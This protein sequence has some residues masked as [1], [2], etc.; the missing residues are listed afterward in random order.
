M[1]AHF[2][3]IPFIRVS[4]KANPYLRE[5]ELDFIFDKKGIKKMCRD[6]LNY[7]TGHDLTF[8]HNTHLLML[9]MCHMLGI[10]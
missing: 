3:H 7:Y 9:P 4:K 8:S 1:Q 2:R 6:V 10:S 5:E